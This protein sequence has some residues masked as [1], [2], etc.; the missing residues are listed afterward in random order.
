M[1]ANLVYFI[2][3]VILL[4]LSAFFS[5]SEAS[6]SSLNL[7]RLK[8]H[9]EEKPSKKKHYAIKIKENYEYYLISLL[10]GNNTVNLLLSN[11]LTLF[12][13]GTLGTKWSF[14]ST[15]ISVTLLL[16]VGEITPKLLGT[17]YNERWAVSTSIYINLL[18][19][20]LFVIVWPFNK[21]LKLMKKNNKKDSVTQEELEAALDKSNDKGIIDDDKK[22][23]VQNAITLDEKCAYEVCT[24]RI[25][26]K[27]IDIESDVSEWINTAVSSEFSRLPV[28][29][30][31]LDNPKGTIFVRDYL[32]WLIENKST[33]D[34]ENK[35][36]L[37]NEITPP[38]FIHHTMKV[39]EV[40]KL[41]NKEK[42]HMAFVSDEWGGT[43]GIITMD[44]AL[45]E[46]V[47][48]IW[49]E[50]D[51]KEDGF[52]LNDD[53]TFTLNGSMSIKDLFFAL[54][55]EINED[56]FESLTVG[57]LAIEML[58]AFPHE[59][60]SFICKGIRFTVLETEGRRVKRL[61]GAFVNG[62][63]LSE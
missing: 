61:M 33:S 62:E 48:E 14:L 38:I 37:L 25:N 41:L 56:E 57:G 30:G 49:D 51:A 50:D 31:S 28:Y 34:E 16:I 54:D 59:G 42:N 55:K 9:N 63:P 19:I 5:S 4:L 29:E 10:F 18:S 23:L 27:G 44:D 24:P 22:E 13:V 53:G 43:Y 45:E 8:R 6:F 2:T 60:D 40:Y 11:V 7:L 58:N 17:K 20:I 26:V 39:D 15:I 35:K 3:I 21:L 36:G 46:L 47:G 12:I 52:E 32:K 1:S